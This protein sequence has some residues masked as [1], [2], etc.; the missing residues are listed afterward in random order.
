MSA[1]MVRGIK[2]EKSENCQNETPNTKGEIREAATVLKGLINQLSSDRARGILLKL[3]SKEWESKS[4]IN[5]N[6]I[7][8]QTGDFQFVLG[9]ERIHI[10]Q[11][12]TSTIGTQTPD[13]PKANKDV[14]ELR[15]KIKDAHSLLEYRDLVTQ[16]WPKEC[17][18]RSELITGNPLGYRGA[19]LLIISGDSA[20]DQAV[21]GSIWKKK[22]AENF[23]ELFERGPDSN[24]PLD[25]IE[26]S[27]R[28]I[29]WRDIDVSNV[30][31]I[32]KLN[33]PCEDSDL[34][35]TTILNSLD[36]LQ[37]TNGPDC[38]LNVVFADEQN[39]LTQIRKCLEC[40]FANTT[41][42]I[43]IYLPK[44]KKGTPRFQGASLDSESNQS[45]HNTVLVKTSSSYVDTLRTV[46]EQFQGKGI[47]DNI[48]KATKTASG[49]L[50]LEVRGEPAV[51]SQLLAEKLPDVQL[52]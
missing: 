34:R 30:T 18:E 36:E 10:E 13:L 47:V 16:K 52:K 1:S 48:T 11:N 19:S 14:T 7:V 3:D 32:F 27:T 37:A 42:T 5:T 46:R 21:P 43:R 38:A 51:V 45:P 23:S 39:M 2:L 22:L 26:M 33:L 8:T 25:C 20:Q 12:P 24:I 4:V 28:R 50:V 41:V 17:Y 31:K 6:V 35:I 29:G 44:R 15:R 9:D 40:V 49:E